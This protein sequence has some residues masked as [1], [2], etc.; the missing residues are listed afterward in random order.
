M[1]RVSSSCVLCRILLPLFR[2]KLSVRHRTLAPAVFRSSRK[3]PL[4]RRAA[5]CLQSL[6]LS[7]PSALL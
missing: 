4:H 2:Q 6:F 3:L 5:L 7:L 1:R